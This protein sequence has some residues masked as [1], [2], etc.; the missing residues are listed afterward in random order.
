MFRYLGVGLIFLAVPSLVLGLPQ[1]V[2]LAI[3]SKDAVPILEYYKFFLGGV[4]ALGGV[5]LGQFGLL[6]LAVRHP[7]PLL[8]IFCF[9]GG[10]MIMY[11]QFMTARMLYD[12]EFSLDFNSPHMFV[13]S[14]LIIVVCSIVVNFVGLTGK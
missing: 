11:S 14:I 3:N 13:R 8:P 12:P 4:L 7:S 2:L 1:L 5:V 6:V 10:A 9:L